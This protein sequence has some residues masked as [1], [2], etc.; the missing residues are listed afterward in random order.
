MTLSEA[1]NTVDHQSELM[2]LRTTQQPYPLPYINN[3]TYVEWLG[4][5]GAGEA[6]LCEFSHIWERIA[7]IRPN[8]LVFNFGLHWLNFVNEVAM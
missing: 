1:I 4:L 8:I 5:V 2:R 3:D 6:E 7:F